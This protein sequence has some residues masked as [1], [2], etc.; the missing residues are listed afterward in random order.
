MTTDSDGAQ[1]KSPVLQDA[2]TQTKPAALKISVPPKMIS[3]GVDPIVLLNL[4]QD[5][6]TPL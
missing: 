3:V 1:P 4:P 6:D 5:L 2:Q